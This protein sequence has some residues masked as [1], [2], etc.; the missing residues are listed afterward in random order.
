MFSIFIFTS[1]CG[2]VMW[3]AYGQ[4]WLQHME[5]IRPVSTL[6]TANVLITQMT[7]AC[8]QFCIQLTA[9][10]STVLFG[11][12]TSVIRSDIHTIHPTYYYNYINI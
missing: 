9:R 1:L 12:L 6:P 5:V 11:S 7:Q 3:T 8:T 2:L 10:L 4:V